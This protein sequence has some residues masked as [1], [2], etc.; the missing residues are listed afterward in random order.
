MDDET[1]ANS[2]KSLFQRKTHSELQGSD[3]QTGRPDPGAQAFSRHHFLPKEV[4]AHTFPDICGDFFFLN[5]QLSQLISN[6]STHSCS[7][8]SFQECF[9]LS[10]GGAPPELPAHLP[11]PLH[12]SSCLPQQ[13]LPP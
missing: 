12:T 6:Y 10:P 1:E 3:W 2:A 4:N 13:I 8:L 5:W 11:V 9:V 7:L